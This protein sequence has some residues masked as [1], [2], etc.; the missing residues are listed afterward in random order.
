MTAVQKLEADFLATVDS[1]KKLA[2]HMKHVKEELKRKKASKML[3]VLER[4][5]QHSGTLSPNSLDILPQLTEKQ[6]LD[7]ISYLQLTV[8]PGI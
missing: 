1:A 6:L 3:I 7:E 4:C 8:A 2:L 5:K